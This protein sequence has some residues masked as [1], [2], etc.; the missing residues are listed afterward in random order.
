[1][2]NARTIEITA[3]T[4]EEARQLAINELN[5]NE[6]IVCSEVI[7]APAKG[8][9]G[10]VGKQEYKI[11][12]SIDEKPEEKP[13]ERGEKL[14]RKTESEGGR[15]LRRHRRGSGHLHGGIRAALRR[16]RQ[17]RRR[18]REIRGPRAVNGRHAK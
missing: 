15:H 11:R 13:V 10:L 8:L 18:V 16:E 1:M 17:L 5:E 7:S 12:F 2:A 6:T 3:K 4:E 14:S 9:F